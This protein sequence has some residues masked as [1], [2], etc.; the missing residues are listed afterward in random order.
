[1]TQTFEKGYLENNYLTE[2]YASGQAGDTFPAQM[3]VVIEQEQKLPAQFR[4]EVLDFT[5]PFAVQYVVDIEGLTNTLS[6]QF[7][8]QI[9]NAI[10]TLA[11]QTQVE[12]LDAQDQLPAQFR[13]EITGGSGLLGNEYKNTFPFFH[14]ICPAYLVEPYLEQPYLQSCST[15]IAGVQFQTEIVE[16]QALPAQF[17][18]EITDVRDSIPAQLRVEIIQPPEGGGGVPGRLLGVQ[19]E[20]FITSKLPVEFNL[21]LYNTKQLRILC[22]FVNRGTL[23]QNGE[24]WTSSSTPPT[25]DYSPNN[26]NDDIVE[27]VT[28]TE[29]GVTSW[30]L[31]CDTGISSAFVD[32]LAIINHNFTSSVS[33][34]LQGAEDGDPTFTNPILNVS[35]GYTRE[36]IYYIADFAAS[37]GLRYFRLQIQDPTNTAGFLKAGTIVFG[38]AFVFTAEE[39]ASNP[40]SFSKTNFVSRVFTEGHS[41]AGLDRGIKRQLGLRFENLRFLGGNYSRLVELFDTSRTLLKCLW[42]P[43]PQYPERFG[44]FGKLTE[45]PSEEHNDLGEGADYVTFDVEVDESR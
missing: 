28:R 31:T 25:G 1:M 5:Q 16:T 43:T 42:I 13:T 40:I 33:I 32:T 27:R 29:Q 17:E 21:N 22:D 30:T 11:A 37:V 45:L 15:A 9:E 3:Q 39:N 44:T 24:T 36:N 41:S 19:F 18:V 6:A 14:T 23:A 26:L 38:Q 4:V 20:N 34:N 2:P 7:R 35:L 12:I 8:T 10:D